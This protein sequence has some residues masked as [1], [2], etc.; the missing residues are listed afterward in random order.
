MAI[1]YGADISNDDDDDDGDDDEEEK[2]ISLRAEE[3][4]ENK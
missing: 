1:E 3:L 4:K 2:E